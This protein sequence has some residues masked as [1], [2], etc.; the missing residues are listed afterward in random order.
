M[1]YIILYML[2]L[3]MLFGAYRLDR[4]RRVIIYIFLSFFARGGKEFFN[5]QNP[6]GLG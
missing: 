6:W 3:I 1:E 5:K 2:S 4:W